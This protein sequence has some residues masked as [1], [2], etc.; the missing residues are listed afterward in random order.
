M[1]QIFRWR[2]HL[3]GVKSNKP[4]GIY[5]SWKPITVNPRYNEPLYNEVLSITRDIFYPSDSKIKNL[6]ITILVI[7]NR[8]WQFLGLSLYRGSTVFHE[9]IEFSVLCCCNYAYLF[10]D[11]SGILSSLQEDMECRSLEFVVKECFENVYMTN[12]R[13]Q[14]MSNN[15]QYLKK[16]WHSVTDLR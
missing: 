2:S 3:L 8:F 1:S 15:Y 14:P 16:L 4:L 9:V 12:N 7:G 6:D 10:G 13:L 11:W 5:I